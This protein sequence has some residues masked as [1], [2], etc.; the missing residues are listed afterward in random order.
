MAFV[1]PIVGIIYFDIIIVY[2]IDVSYKNIEVLYLNYFKNLVTNNS[3]R[4][5]I[6]N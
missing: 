2:N 3:K 5:V 6:I 1:I 4:T